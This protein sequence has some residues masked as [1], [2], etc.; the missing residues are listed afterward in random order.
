MTAPAK[1]TL[2]GLPD[3]ATVFLRLGLTAFG[4]PAAHIALMRQEFVERRNWL[5]EAEFL[6]LLGAS[7]LIPGPS[8]TELAIHIGFRRAGWIGL[9][10]AGTCFILPAFLLVMA[11]ARAYMRFG[12]LPQVR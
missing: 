6:D 11:I 3:L 4:G 10:I 2:S 5:T 7:N 9:L 1:A 8:S 12:Y